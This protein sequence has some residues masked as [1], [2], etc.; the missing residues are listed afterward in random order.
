MSEK[1]LL[2]TES[3]DYLTTEAG[4]Y[5]ELYGYPEYSLYVDWDGDGD[6]DLICG[7]TAGFLDFVENLGGGAEPSWAEPVGAEM[8]PPTAMMR[9]RAERSTTRS[10][11]TGNADARHGS[12]TMVSPSRNVR[13]WS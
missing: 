3:G 11:N 9:S 6:E 1:V 8:N 7:N 4:D 10:R 12:I 13:M 2:V 5:I